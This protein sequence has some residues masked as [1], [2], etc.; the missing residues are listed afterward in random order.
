MGDLI[1]RFWEWLMAEP[2]AWEEK[3]R[4]AAP[5]RYYGDG[6]TIH[7]TGHLDVEV[8]DGQ[9]VSVWFR[10]QPL[11]FKQ[12]DVGESRGREMES[13]YAEVR[14]IQLTGVEVLDPEP[15]QSRR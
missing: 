10:C 9:V 4:L 12:T 13:M 8:R 2:T 15:I 5:S 6:G 3:Q 11:P 1:R 14:D 7:H